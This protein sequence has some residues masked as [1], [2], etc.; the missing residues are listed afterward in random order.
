MTIT[1]KKSTNNYM[2]DAIFAGDASLPFQYGGF[3][4]KAN[5]LVN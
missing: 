1:N 2:S 5:S 4:N 3:L